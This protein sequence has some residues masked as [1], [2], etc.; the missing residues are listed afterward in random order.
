MQCFW[1]VTIKTESSLKHFY[2]EAKWLWQSMI[3]RF[4][5]LLKTST[6]IQISHALMQGGEGLQKNAYKF[7]LLDVSVSLSV[8]A[9]VVRLSETAK[10]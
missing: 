1:Q 4:G 5:H 3:S 7:N 2:M 10:I 6:V 8:L 9:L